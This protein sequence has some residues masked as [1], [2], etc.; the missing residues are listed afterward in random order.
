MNNLKNKTAKTLKW[1]LIDR[2]LQ[3]LLYAV[4]GIVLARMLSQ[5]DFGLV[6]A[7]LV[8]QAFA[9][10]LIDSGFSFALIQR[11]EPTQTDYSTVLWFNLGAAAVLY[12]IL[13]FAAPLIALCFQNDLRLIPLSRVMFL[14]IILNASAI[15][16]TN[17]L[18]KQM[19]VRPVTVSNAAGLAAG[20]IAGIWLAVSG[21][22][23]WAIVWQTLVAAAVKSAILWFGCNWRPSPVFSWTALRSFFGIGGRMM[24]TSFLNTLFLNLYSLFIGAFVGLRSLGFYTQSDKWSKMGIMSISQTLTSSFLPPLS[25]VQDDRERFRRMTSKMNRFTAYILFP[26]MLGLMAMATPVFHLLFGTKWDP[27]ILLF[28]LLLL[29]GV[30]TVLNALYNN[31]LLALGHAR[32]IM[33]LEVLRDSVAVVALAIT[34]PYM[35]LCTADDPVY[36]L[37]ILLWGQLAS[38]AITYV[39]TLIVVCRRV[40]ISPWNYLLDLAP[41]A[42]L[43]LAI[44]PLMLWAG[45]L[46]QSPLLQLLAEAVVAL[47]LYLGINRLLG[48]RIQTDVLAFARGKASFE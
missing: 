30:F 32:S 29:R 15:V 37:A 26:A 44:I 5:T 14:S 1:T 22:G 28:Q 24:F 11:K 19:N 13:W 36:G 35:G 6:G 9:S 47:A 21:F 27:S 39:A 40:E 17:R 46:T 2:V 33:W 16:Q 10:L 41:Y 4:T 42:A 48:S 31:Y 3:Q 45:S 34:F 8:F 12:I 23:A 7:V 38:S 20:A 18:M 43:T 25:A